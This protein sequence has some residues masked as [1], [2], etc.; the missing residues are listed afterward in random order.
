VSSNRKFE[1]LFEPFAIRGVKLKN[2]MVKPAQGMVFASDDG[3][4]TERN[5]GF[6][7]ALARGGVGLII[8]EIACV[9][10]PGGAS[11]P[12]HLAIDDDKYIPG[13]SDLAKAIHKHGCPT[14]IQ[15]GHAGLKHPVAFSGLQPVGASSLTKEQFPLSTG[16]KYTP[17]KELT[18]PEIEALVDKF[19]RA[20]GRAQEAGFDGVE[21]HACHDYLINGFLSRVWNKRQDAYG[22]RDL[23]SRSRFVVEIVQA[24]KDR[25]GSNYPVVARINGAEYGIKDGITS[26]ESQGFSRILEEAGADAIHVSAW[27]FNDYSR[28]HTPEI[29]FYPEAPDLLAENIDGRNHGAGALVPLSTAI[30]KGVSIPVI[31]VGR[32]NPLLA[33]QVLREGKADLISFGRRLMADPELPNK[34]ASG[35]L[36]DIAP[37]TACHECVR[38]IQ[39]QMSATSEGIKCRINAAFGREYEYAIKPAVKRKR[40]LVIGGGPSGMEAARVAALRGH[41]VVLCE[42]EPKLGGLLPLAAMVR[43][44]EKEDLPAL[45]NYL[46]TQISKLGVEVRL[47]KEVN[48][49]VVKE[50]KP[51]VVIV[52]TGGVPVPLT[53]PGM[54]RGNV[55]TSSYFHRMGKTFLKFLTPEVLRWLTKFWIPLGKRVVVVGGSIHGCELAEFLV[56]R[57]RKV[58]LIET[59][60]AM[61]TEMVETNRDRLLRWLAQKGVTM[62]TGVKYEEIT[63]KGIVI[64]TK[65]GKKQTIEADTIALITGLAPNIELFKTLEGKVP[66]IHRI[67]DCEQPG[68]IVN[69]IHAGSHIG[70]AV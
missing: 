67:G 13:L 52:A 42:K 8:V 51:D 30:K 4:V 17:G 39:S 60:E 48:E 25:T 2:R 41:N 69:A 27:G 66:E 28:I 12:A 9:D 61:G 35:R 1:K 62:M 33:E 58:T 45:V 29:V 5:R 50:I 47:G 63:D 65:E 55:V 6:Y 20:A 24:I 38:W 59:S 36:E 37:C 18:I 15:L 21:L 56:K 16:R 11:G 31:A 23:R 34:L 22:C 70:R 49:A 26:E 10:F 54:D 40:V 32:F 3:F 64:R 7:E 43:G 19:A 44:T 14:F 53:I 46:K 57:G 68:L